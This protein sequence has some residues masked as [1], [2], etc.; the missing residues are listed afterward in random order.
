MK[1]MFRVTVGYKTET[2]IDIE[3]LDETEAANAALKQVE[4]E[5]DN[6]WY[7]IFGVKELVSKSNAA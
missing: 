2:E 4:E 3:A 7:E 5:D 6:E 1:K